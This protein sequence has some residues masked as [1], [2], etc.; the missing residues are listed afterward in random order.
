MTEAIAS[1]LQAI[2]V[3]LNITTEP[4]GAAY[5]AALA[6]HKF[7]GSTADGGTA[8][9]WLFATAAFNNP[10]VYDQHNFTNVPMQA[11]EAKAGVA[12]NPVPYYQ[13]MMGLATVQGL[14]LPVAK[15]DNLWY[16]ARRIAG[17]SATSGT[18]GLANILEWYPTK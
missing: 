12:K 7:S 15:I 9:T 2:G 14:A 4:T 18:Q 10:S 11:L 5:T 1:D 17:V 6:S 13:Q 8:L 3:T 16:S